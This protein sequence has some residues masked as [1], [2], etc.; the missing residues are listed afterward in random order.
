ML[1]RSICERK[2]GRLYQPVDSYR[3]SRARQGARPRRGQRILSPLCRSISAGGVF[4]LAATPAPVHSDQPALLHI[5]LPVVQQFPFME[6]AFAQR[7]T[8]VFIRE[9]FLFK[10]EYVRHCYMLADNAAHG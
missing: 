6:P 8:L 2:K 9:F 4:L 10:S 1:G 3:Y 7:F 5:K